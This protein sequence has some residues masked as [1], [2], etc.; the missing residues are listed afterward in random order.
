MHLL[1]ETHGP[2]KLQ[3]GQVYFTEKFLQILQRQIVNS[4]HDGHGNFTLLSPGE[5][6]L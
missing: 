5:T 1:P 4:P 2:S 6:D 3:L